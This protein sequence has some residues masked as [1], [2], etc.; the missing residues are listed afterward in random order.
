MKNAAEKMAPCL[1]FTDGL[2]TEI[3]QFIISFRL[4]KF[5]RFL[6]RQVCR[7]PFLTTNIGRN[8]KNVTDYNNF[9]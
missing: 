9:F 6:V 8:F 7:F 3:K 1:W 5:N 4:H 2:I